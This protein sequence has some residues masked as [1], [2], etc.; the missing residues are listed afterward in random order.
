MYGQE[1]CQIQ[2]DKSEAEL[3]SFDSDPSICFCFV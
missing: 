2:C 1:E 3:L